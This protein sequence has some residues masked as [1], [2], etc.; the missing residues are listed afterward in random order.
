MIAVAG[1]VIAIIVA[2]IFFAP[3]FFSKAGNTVDSELKKAGKKVG[4][5]LEATV[6][7]TVNPDPKTENFVEYITVDQETESGKLIDVGLGWKT[8]TG[9]EDVEKLV[10]KRTVNGEEIQENIEHTGEG[11]DNYSSGKILF[12]GEGIKSSPVGENKIEIYYTKPGSDEQIKLTEITVSVDQ[13]DLAMTTEL[14]APKTM[15]FTPK[16]KDDSFA[17]EL[18]SE[19]VY[20][21]LK[22]NSGKS[23]VV[24][25]KEDPYIF[26]LD[27]KKTGDDDVI[28]F[29]TPGEDGNDVNLT[30]DG[31]TDF[32]LK[33]KKQ[34]VYFL[35]TADGKA[36]TAAAPHRNKI[37]AGGSTG[38]ITRPFE[39]MT[40]LQYRAS[41][42]KIVDTKSVVKFPKN[43]SGLSGRYV[44]SS[45]AADKWNDI[46]G[47]GNHCTEVKGS[48]KKTNS[49]VYGN[50]TD[51]FRFPKATMG[52]DN[53]Y[54]LFYIARYN[55][56]DR[57]RIFDGVDSNWLSGFHNNNTGIA[58]H[59]NWLAYPGKD[60][61][62]H[63]QVWFQGTDQNDVF[64][65]NGISMVTNA[66]HNGTT[67]QITVNHGE[68]TPHTNGHSEVSDWAIKEVLIY[69]RKLSAEEIVKVEQYLEFTYPEYKQDPST[70]LFIDPEET[71]RSYST[72]WGKGGD[73]ELNQ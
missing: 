54:T 53:V 20:Y 36:V 1:I 39:S 25:D 55:G 31:N 71:H 52:A 46:S 38:L 10:F 41:M 34:D 3:K 28:A 49:Y 22:P 62:I 2:L 64:R 21:V 30:I 19:K 16:T 68:Y 59:G 26:T 72:Y 69:N 50:S 56:I 37:P 12:D 32:I 7:K 29:K 15:V 48:L 33:K 8:T 23:I 35:T 60:Y 45:A 44:T 47:A 13:K 67:S 4:P 70:V 73:V 57:G 42:F 63:G 5:Q 66:S 43:I 40:P 18:V 27:I 14:L 51:G 9:F 6:I 61:S 65:S 24:D 11:V 58:H 17:A